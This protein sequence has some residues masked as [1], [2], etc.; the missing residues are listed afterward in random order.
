[1]EDEDLAGYIKQE[2]LSRELTGGVPAEGTFT[3]S[4]KLSGHEI[5]L[6]VCRLD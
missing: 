4:Y 5:L 6:G 1:M 2:T 3:E